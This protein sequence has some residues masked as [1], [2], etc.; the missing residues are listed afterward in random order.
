MASGSRCPECA[1][2]KKTIKRKQS[3]IDR[4]NEII[5]EWDFKN[6]FPKVPEDFTY[7]SGKLVWWICPKEHNYQAKINN[8]TSNNSNCPFCTGRKVSV[9]NTFK[10]NFPDLLQ[11]WDTLRNKR[12]PEEFICGLH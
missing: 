9:E 12:G 10:I 11:E 4:Y 5:K 6:N 7:G 8:R 2:F 3:A 1:P